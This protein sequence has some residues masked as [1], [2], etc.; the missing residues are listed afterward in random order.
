MY[1]Q[2]NNSKDSTYIQGNKFYVLETQPEEL[3]E[4]TSAQILTSSEW[5]LGL[6]LRELG[7]KKQLLKQNTKHNIQAS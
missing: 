2:A 3:T 6:L 7:G 5:D 1:P 4:T